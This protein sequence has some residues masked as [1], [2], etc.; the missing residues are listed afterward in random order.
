MLWEL[1]RRRLRYVSISRIRCVG[2]PR[3]LCDPGPGG[4]SA[5]GFSSE[6]QTIY[7]PPGLFRASIADSAYI[8]EYAFL[9]FT[10]PHLVY[11]CNRGA[12][13]PDANAS[14][15]WALS[16][17]AGCGLSSDTTAQAAYQCL[18]NTPF[19]KLLN[20]SETLTNAGISWPPVIAGSF[21]DEPPLRR[22]AARKYNTVPNIM[23]TN[24]DE[25]SLYVLRPA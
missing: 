2:M 17:S 7:A 13:F 4:E 25:G 8:T 1:T 18:V 23:G 5:G 9:S 11:E 3:I 10:P 14:S 12:Q 22:L 24:H 6:A 19:D 20:V 16:N 15:F 21:L